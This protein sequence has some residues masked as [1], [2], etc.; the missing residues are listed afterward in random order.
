M[1]TLPSRFA[2]VFGPCTALV[3]FA[4]MLQPVEGG[5]IN[6]DAAFTPREGGGILRLQY[7]FEEADDNGPVQHVSESAA[8]AVL[9]YGL[10]SNLALFLNVPY[11][12]RQVDRFDRRF[13]RIE[14]AH[15]GVGDITVMAK[16]RFYQKDA[17]PLDTA[18][19][20]VLGGLNVRS[21]DSDFSSDSYNPI[22]GA[23]FSWRKERAK[24]DADL[25]YRF[26][27]GRGDKRHDMLRYDLTY[28]H[29]VYP[30]EYGEEHTYEIDAVA[31]INGR[32]VTDG[33]HEVF[34]SPGVVWSWERVSFELSVQ[35]PALQDLAGG[36]PETD[37]RAVAGLRFRW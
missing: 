3:T 13:G 15:D 16:Y 9:V 23:V 35:I 6:S 29:R 7:T 4:V 22:V 30:A 24:L 5:P 33:A 20:A 34:V 25:I 2:T 8:R 19:I 26:N 32:Y 27:T 17:G 36:A 18:R 10:K 31:E 12:N 21:G 14:D 37:Y 1:G 28:S 11:V